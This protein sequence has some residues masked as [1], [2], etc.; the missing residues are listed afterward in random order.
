MSSPQTVQSD[1]THHEE[2]EK[3]LS[4]YNPDL[5]NE[6]LLQEVENRFTLFPIQIP[7]YGLFHFQNLEL[8]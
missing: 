3:L 1:F 5:K 6:F 7:K 2:L 4:E 8:E